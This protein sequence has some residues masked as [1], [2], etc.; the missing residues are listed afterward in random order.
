[1][2][3]VEISEVFTMLAYILV[4]PI[5]KRKKSHSS[6]V[7]VPS[8]YKQTKMYCALL[9]KTALSRIYLE[10]WQ[11]KKKTEFLSCFYYMSLFKYNQIAPQ[12]D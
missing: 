1:M 5:H 8:P 12:G 4:F 6:T 7:T 2:Q 9:E 3:S 10:I 11:S